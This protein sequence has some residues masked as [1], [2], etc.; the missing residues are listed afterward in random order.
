MATVAILAGCGSSQS[1]DVHIRGRLALAGDGKLPNHASARISLIEHDVGGGEN[2]IVAERTLHD[3]GKL[4]VS[5]NISVGSA[6]LGSGGQYGLSAQIMDKGG[7]VRWQTPVPQAVTPREQQKPALLMLQANDS[8]AG[9]D[10]RHYR[11]DDDFRFDMAHTPKQAILHMGKRQITL[12]AKKGSGAQAAV[13]ADDHGDQLTFGHD[14]ITLN[15][16]GAS[17]MNCVAQGETPTSPG[18]GNPGREHP[19]GEHSS[20]GN[21]AK[22]PRSSASGGDSQ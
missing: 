6:L 16:D 2:R 8:G 3:L 1:Q 21:E 11:C 10:F 20:A 22:T 4:P 13:Y 19:P 17:H 14:K 7:D 12:E 9:G 5:F 15:I 18:N